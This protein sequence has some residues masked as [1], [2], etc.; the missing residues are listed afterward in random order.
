MQ[1]KPYPACAKVNSNAVCDDIIG[2]TACGKY[3]GQML[4]PPAICPM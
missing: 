4:P 2:A 3:K 1:L